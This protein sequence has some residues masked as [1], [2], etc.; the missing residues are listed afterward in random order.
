VVIVGSA[1][2][3]IIKAFVLFPATFEA[4]TEKLNV[5]VVVRVP[6]INPVLS[7]KLNP[8]GRVPLV[9]DQIIGVVPVA[10]SL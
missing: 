3:S 1:V 6:E 8:T 2:T 7:F 10:A 4:L 5:P 9:I